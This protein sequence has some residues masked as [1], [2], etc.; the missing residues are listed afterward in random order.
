MFW[1]VTAPTH[2]GDVD[3]HQ[4]FGTR[5]GGHHHP[6]RNRID[7]LQPAADDLVNRLPVARIGQ[8][9]GDLADVLEPRAGFRQQHR[10]IAHGL[11]G[12]AGGIADRHAERGVEVL[13]DLAAH[14]HHGAARHDHLTQVVIERLVGVGLAGIE[15]A[16]PFVDHVFSPASWL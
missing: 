12:L 9:D 16:Y 2:C 3:L 7:P 1:L 13:T 15:L 10:H 8:I 14:E 4:P 5:Q 6:G 11:F